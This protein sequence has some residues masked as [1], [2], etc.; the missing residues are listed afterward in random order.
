MVFNREGNWGDMWSR[1]E[2][3]IDIIGKVNVVG[4]IG[5]NLKSSLEEEI[6]YDRIKME[7]LRCESLEYLKKVLE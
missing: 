6:Q 4:T 1:I 2:T 5:E 7:R 3:L